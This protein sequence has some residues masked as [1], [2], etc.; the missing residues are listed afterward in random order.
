MVAATA[1][2]AGPRQSAWIRSQRWDLTFLILSA[3]LV[4]VPLL[5]Y[6]VL[7]VSSEAIN[8]IVAGLVGGPHMYSTFTLTFLDSS[9]RQRYPLYT[10]CALLVPVAVIVL[11]VVNISLLFTVFMAWASFHVLQQLGYLTDCYRAQAGEPF[12]GYSQAIDYA[13]LFTSLYPVALYKMS[14]DNFFINDSPIHQ[15]F[16][17]P[18]KSDLVVYAMSTVFVAVLALWLVKTYGEYRSGRLNLPRTLLIG[19]SVPLAF[20]IP[21]VGNLDVAFQGMNV[22]HSFQYLALLWY[23]NVL[24]H[25]RGEITNPTVRSIAGLA[26]TWHFYGFH[27]GL[28]IASGVAILALYG[29]ATLV[30]LGLSFVQCYSMVVLSWLLMHYYFDTGIFAGV[31]RLTP[32]TP[33]IVPGLRAFL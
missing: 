21:M 9:F 1:T 14:T 15:Y 28:T 17:A 12:S 27:V 29:V 25:E 2:W 32:G 4:P 16:P 11:A 31:G 3:V 24:R 18:L 10:A 7:G 6:Y 22:W 33:A 26:R 30:G 23:L 13:V 8:L 5:L 19:I 20:F